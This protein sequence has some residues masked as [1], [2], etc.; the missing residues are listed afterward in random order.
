MVRCIAIAMTQTESEH[1]DT[2]IT[3]PKKSKTI[4]ICMSGTAIS[5]VSYSETV[6]AYSLIMM[7][8]S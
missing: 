2:N 7:R 3:D 4:L 8:M 1:I 5:I 6:A